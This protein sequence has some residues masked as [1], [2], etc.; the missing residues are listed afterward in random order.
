[1]TM[2]AQTLIW[3]VSSQLLQTRHPHPRPLQQ[4]KPCGQS[5]LLFLQTRGVQFCRT[6]VPEAFLLPVDE[7]PQVFSPLLSPHAKRLMDGMPKSRRKRQ[8]KRHS[9]LFS[10][11]VRAGRSFSWQPQLRQAGISYTIKMPFR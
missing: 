8:W 3:H 2:H 11:K 5:Q 4:P 10:F 7:Y 1:M 6:N 9:T